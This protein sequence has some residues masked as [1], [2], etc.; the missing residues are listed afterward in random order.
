MKKVVTLSIIALI[1]AGISINYWVNK[2]LEFT[3]LE[4]AESY[5][6]EFNLKLTEPS[7][8]ERIWSSKNNAFGDGEWYSILHYEKELLKPA[9]AGLSLITVDTLGQVNQKVA[10]FI[11]NTV[12]EYNDNDASRKDFLMAVS[13]SPIKYSLNDYYFHRSENKDFDTFT[14][15]YNV[16]QKKLYVLEWHQ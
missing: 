12:G 9:D 7:A 1:F 16:G 11:S 15:I 13:N 10:Q 5:N 3:P 14:A 4:V 8:F 6:N 2:K